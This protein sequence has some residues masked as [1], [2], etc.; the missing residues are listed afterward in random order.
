MSSNRGENPLNDNVYQVQLLKPLDETNFIVS[1]TNADTNEPLNNVDVNIYDDEDNQIASLKTNPKG[2]AQEIVISNLEYDIQANLDE[3]DSESKTVS[4]KGDVMEIN[5]KLK[6]IEK[7]IEDREITLSN[8]LFDFDK[9]TIRP[10]AAFEL[11]KIAATLKKYPD[12]IIKIESHTD[13]RGSEIY[14]QNLSEARAQNTMEYLIEKGIDESRLS[15]E[16][17]GESEPLNDCA[18]GC[19]EEEHEQNRRSKFIIVE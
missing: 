3:Y 15:A 2:E 17:K 14:N 19:T 5:L 7:I 9:A 13:L 18:D 12:L 6:P 1:V 16:G 4:A 10:E 11:D 8:V